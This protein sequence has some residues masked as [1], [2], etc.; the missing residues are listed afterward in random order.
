MPSQIKTAA[1][2]DRLS[3]QR[4]NASAVHIGDVR[5][6]GVCAR[7]GMPGAAAVYNMT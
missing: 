2:P 4:C 7:V 1:F 5:N 6:Y 3:L